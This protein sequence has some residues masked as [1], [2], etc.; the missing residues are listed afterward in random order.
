MP[1]ELYIENGY[2][3]PRLESAVERA[4][5]LLQRVES[6][7][8]GLVETANTAFTLAGGNSPQCRLS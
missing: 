3:T 2:S 4:I 6:S 1:T 8:I 7:F 5:P